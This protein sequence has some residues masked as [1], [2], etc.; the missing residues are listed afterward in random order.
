MLAIHKEYFDRADVR[1]ISLTYFMRAFPE[2]EDKSRLRGY[3]TGQVLPYLVSH[4]SA[5]KSRLGKYLKKMSTDEISAVID[6][7]FRVVSVL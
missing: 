4:S 3:W 5:E 6:D 2:F 1:V 7:E